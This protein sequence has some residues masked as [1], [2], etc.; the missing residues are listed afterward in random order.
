VPAIYLSQSDMN[1]TMTGELRISDYE[2]FRVPPRWVFLKIETADGLIGWGEPI[3]EGRAKTVV[4]AVEEL[5]DT[6]LLNENPLHI[7]D[8]WQT[9]YRG[10]FYRG[11][12]ILMSAIAGIDQAL[13]DIKGKYYDAPI[14]ELLG[15]KVRD[16]IRYYRWVGGDRPTEVGKNAATLVE[17]GITAVKMNATPEFER[18]ETP[19]KIKQA[20]E[21]LKTVREA[22]GDDIK[23]GVDFHGR[24]AKSMVPRIAKELEPYDPMFLEEPVLPENNDILPE[25]TATTTVPIATGERLFSRWDFK[26]ILEQGVIDV[27]QPDPSHAGGI[28]EVMKI[29]SMAEAYDVAVA[30]HC[31]LGPISLASALQ[32]DAVSQTAIIQE[33]SLGMHYNESADVP[34]YL[35]SDDIFEPVGGFLQIPDEPGLGIT[36][37][38]E[39]IRDTED[40]DWHNPVWRYEDGSVAEW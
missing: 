9:M 31:P 27:I 25:I 1:Y 14:H 18:I 5:L 39:R 33:S 34:D 40:T 10:G 19:R 4:T 37:D 20:G 32:I 6:Y 13:W 21:R 15:G 38:E 12:P 24:V 2:L 23:I 7:Q 36:L 26:S 3:V 17:Q 22:V 29:A 8:H 28:T 16:K 35:K 30:P 11:G